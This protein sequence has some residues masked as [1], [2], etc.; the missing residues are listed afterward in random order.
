MNVQVGGRTI[1]LR[2]SNSIGQGGEA[3][4][5]DIGKGVALKIWKPPRHPDFAGDPELM[6]AAEERIEEQQSKLLAYP[7]THPSRILAPIEPAFEPGGSRVA[8]YTMR[9]VRPADPIHRLGERP[10]RQSGFGADQVMSVLRDLHE[11]VR[12]AHRAGI[13]IGDFNDLNVLV[14]GTEAW[15]IDA[16]SYQFDRFLCRL[17]TERFVDPLHCDAAQPRPVMIEPH[18][19]LSD[20]FAF[21]AIAFRSLLLLDP[22]GGVYRAGS[23]RPAIPQPAR[24]LRGISALHADVVYPRPA[25]RPEVLPDELLQYFVEVFEKG[26]RGRYPEEHLALRFQ[27]CPTCG[28]SYA[29][30]RCPVCPAQPAPAAVIACVRVRGKVSCETVAKTR[31]EILHAAFDEGHLRWIEQS[32]GRIRRE[33]GSSVLGCEPATNARFWIRGDAT[34]LWRGRDVNVVRHGRVERQIPIETPHQEPA[35][36][37]TRDHEYWVSDGVLYRDGR[38]GPERIGSTLAGQTRI[39]AG[40]TFGLGYYRAGGMS[41]VFVFDSQRNGINDSVPCRLPAGKLVTVR[42]V[43]S[44]THAFLIASAIANG[45]TAHHAW[46]ILPSGEVAAQSSG[47]DWLDRTA[48]FTSLCAIGAYLFAATDEG[49]IRIEAD[50]DRLVVSREFPDTEPFADPACSIL[51][52]PDGLYVVDRR[53]IRLVRIGA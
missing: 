16:D 29:R 27:R 42:C 6:R 45:R 48:P 39:F 33:D 46:M 24:P 13:V 28:T 23:G 10:F 2:A 11:T 22:Y 53:E 32:D 20:W 3:E 15:L 41:K 50:R 18:D 36:D 47:T 35:F 38:L 37:L 5:Y 12:E 49:V 44:G 4:V 19:T 1:R 30:D 51:P 9:L 7:R 17:Y 43:F 8:G 25:E 21:S 52:A 31:G 40:P 34:W 14:S 26:R